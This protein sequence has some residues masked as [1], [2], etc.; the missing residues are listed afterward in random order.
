MKNVKYYFFTLFVIFLFFL[1]IELTFL[2]TY[3]ITKSRYFETQHEYNIQRTFLEK[4]YPE[5]NLNFFKDLKS[6]ETKIAIFGGSSA[7]GWGSPINF[8]E[9]LLAIDPSIV[10]HNYAI[11]GKPFAGFQSQVLKR[12]LPYYDYIII[13]A[14]HNE[15]LGHLYQ[16][17]FI[18]NKTISYPNNIFYGQT[19]TSFFYMEE[20]K[21]LNN[22]NQILLNN[23]KESYISSTDIYMQELKRLNNLDKVLLNNNN[24]I[25]NIAYNS[26]LFNFYQKLTLK[27]YKFINN[28]NYPYKKEDQTFIPFYLDKPILTSDDKKMLIKNYKEEIE[29]IIK[30]MQPNQKLIISTILSNDLYPPLSDHRQNKD[31]EKIKKLNLRTKLVYEKIIEEN[32]KVFYFYNKNTDNKNYVPSKI[33]N[34]IKHLP[35]GSHKSYFNGINCLA[36][37]QSLE[38]YQNCLKILKYAKNLDSINMRAL[39]ELNTFIRSINNKYPNI[40]IADPEKKIELHSNAQYYLSL[41]IDFQHPSS[42]GHSVVAEEIAKIIFQKQNISIKKINDC[43][44]Y[45]INIDKINKNIIPNKELIHNR[46]NEQNIPW[47]ETFIK[48]SQVPFLLNYY[49][50]EAKKKYQTCFN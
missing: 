16:K 18:T 38:N 26:R 36:N 35:N 8:A 23:K 10:I 42:H 3:K 17:A 11:N 20:L 47:L 49:R 32:S 34:V 25:S 19:I 29:S 22:L 39:T 6:K 45:L 46:I 13:Y 21:R 30:L 12:I 24:Y 7:K 2:V 9:F 48:W 14:G 15:W 28:L 40:Y 4:L 44:Q 33:N 50:D 31:P 5:N 27:I 1:L 43:D 41:F 37:S